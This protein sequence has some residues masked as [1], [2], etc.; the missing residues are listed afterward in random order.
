MSADVCRQQASADIGR[1]GDGCLLLSAPY[2]GAAAS[3]H[4]PCL[5]FLAI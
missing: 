1:D 2:K 5:G 3:I 4:H